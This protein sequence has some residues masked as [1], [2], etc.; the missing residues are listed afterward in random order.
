MLFNRKNLNRRWY[1]KK[2]W[3]LVL[4]VM[5]IALYRNYAPDGAVL[6]DQLNDL[7]NALPGLS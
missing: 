6:L 3:W 7:W 4:L 1:R 2:R 5:G